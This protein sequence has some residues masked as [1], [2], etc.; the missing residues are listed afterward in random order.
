MIDVK[1]WHNLWEIKKIKV[2]LLNIMKHFH[3]NEIRGSFRRDTV[4]LRINMKS[5]AQTLQYLLAPL[6]YTLRAKTAFTRSLNDPSLTTTSRERMRS[7]K[8]L[9]AYYI[10]C[11]PSRPVKDATVSTGVTMT[12]TLTS[13][14]FKMNI[15]SRPIGNRRGRGRERTKAQLHDS[16]IRKHS[17]GAVGTLNPLP[18]FQ[19]RCGR[20]ACSRRVQARHV[21]HNAR[22]CH[23]AKAEGAGSCWFA[24]GTGSCIPSRALGL[25]NLGFN[26][27]TK[28]R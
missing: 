5:A 17:V 18:R 2:I 7:A 14:A 28:L 4:F 11:D 10:Y 6:M 8:S 20:S 25:A 16:G 22:S 23:C 27:A 13:F 3:S 24:V 21:R 1:Q 26:S 9:P 19:A 15:L 12:K